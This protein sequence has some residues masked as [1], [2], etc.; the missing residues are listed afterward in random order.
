M[1]I[2]EREID[3]IVGLAED[4]R[5]V[6]VVAHDLDRGFQPDHAPIGLVIRQR[7]GCE[8]VDEGERENGKHQYGTHTAHHPFE[9]RRHGTLC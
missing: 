2:A 4:M 6:V 7:P 1:G 8:V 5:H 3:V 9:E